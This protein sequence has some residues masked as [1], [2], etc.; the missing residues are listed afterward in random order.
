LSTS[1]TIADQIWIKF[2][3]TYGLLPI[4]GIPPKNDGISSF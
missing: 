3:M 2:P 4:D 1:Q